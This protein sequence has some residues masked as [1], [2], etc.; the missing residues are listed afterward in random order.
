MK[1][2]NNANAP[3]LNVGKFGLATFL[4]VIYKIQIF[5]PCGPYQEYV[6]QRKNTTALKF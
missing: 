1:M 5:R 3:F 4:A 6:D 2:V